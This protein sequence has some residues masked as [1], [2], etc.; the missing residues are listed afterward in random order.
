MMIIA[1]RDCPSSDCRCGGNDS[2]LQSLL[3]AVFLVAEAS[4]GMICSAA[5]VYEHTEMG[6]PSLHFRCKQVVSCHTFQSIWV[7]EL[8][9]LWA[10]LS[11][12]RQISKPTQEA[13]PCSTGSSLGLR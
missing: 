3:G 6:L 9:E 5:L 10:F 1:S 12:Q 11:R 2:Q 4:A 8:S 7:Y 13:G